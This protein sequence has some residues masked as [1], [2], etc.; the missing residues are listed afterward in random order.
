MKRIALLQTDLA[1]DRPDVEI[2]KY[3]LS[4]SDRD[5]VVSALKEADILVC[6]MNLLREDSFKFLLDIQDDLQAA[7]SRGAGLICL[8]TRPTI[9]TSS[10]TKNVYAWVPGIGTTLKVTD[11]LVTKVVQE[12][13]QQGPDLPPQIIGSLFATCAFE[14]SSLDGA[15]AFLVSEDK[16]PVGIF[17][18]TG[19]GFVML[20]PQSEDKKGLLTA[21]VSWSAGRGEAAAAPAPATPP[22]QP[23]A[24][25]ASSG[26]D[27]D[28]VMDLGAAAEPAA[29]SGD[30]GVASAADLSVASADDLQLESDASAA[31]AEETPGDGD[32]VMDLGALA[33]S[34]ATAEPEKPEE[35]VSASTLSFDAPADSTSHSGSPPDEAPAEDDPF[36][37]RLS[38]DPASLSKA[39]VP[40]KQAAPDQ[41][42]FMPRTEAV[43]AAPALVPEMAPASAPAEST[44]GESSEFD[45]A[46]N[47]DS[48]DPFGGLETSDWPGLDSSAGGGEPKA[49]EPAPEPVPEPQPP[50]VAAPVA[51]ETPAAPVSTPDAPA[52]A[53]AVRPD[54]IDE[55]HSSLPGLSDIIDR[56][57]DI[58][59]EI[60]KLEDEHAALQAK[61]GKVDG[62]T[63]LVTGEPETFHRAVRNFFG[64][65]LSTST[66][67]TGQGLIVADAGIGKFLVLPVTKE[68]L[69]K[70]DVGRLLL[71]ALA[72]ADIQTK[73]VLVVNQER[74]KN[75][76]QRAPL[77]QDL[78]EL[79]RRRDFV[80][81]PS[82]LLYRVAVQHAL[83]LDPPNAIDLVQ[84]IYSSAGPITILR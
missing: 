30:T 32:A 17:R 22:V 84:L 1:L 27:A 12:P 83:D 38:F 14:G 29:S 23:P 75:A 64:N 24:E 52:A 78:I 49:A 53:A 40:E 31:S 65:I 44:A 2:A 4:S 47:L 16:T 18:G 67:I 61:R 72:D 71:H 45:K 13:G 5:V 15:N 70:A 41:T 39:P 7:I 46:F 48:P 35:A 34:A 82:I 66:E 59:G 80:L 77:E 76:L 33:A 56:Q 26:V 6:D 9:R 28:E 43:A 20:L 79:S 25:A 69:A 57:R 42:V 21:V 8:T 36:S 54:W 68:G 81:L 11:D 50:S 19:S 51:A 74:E 37:K 55:L 73:G 58:R 62:W 3:G 63:P 60:Q 10:G